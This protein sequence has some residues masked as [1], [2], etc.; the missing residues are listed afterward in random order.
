M[1]GRYDAIVIGIGSGHAAT[2]PPPHAY[3]KKR[4]AIEGV[5]HQTGTC[6]MG[7]YLLSSVLD[8]NC[9]A[10]DLNNPYVVDAAFF[11]S[12]GAVNP[13]LTIIANAVR[14][15]DHLLSERLR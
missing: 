9:K 12:D 11:A 3:F 10:H 6:R 1:F 8:L 4:I 2:P 13:S 15:A 5:G 14:V 7:T